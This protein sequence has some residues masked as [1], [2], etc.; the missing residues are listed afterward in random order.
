ML[1]ENPQNR[2][3]LPY[4]SINVKPEGLGLGLGLGLNFAEN[5]LISLVV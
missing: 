4:A 2:N 5:W 3:E 1:L